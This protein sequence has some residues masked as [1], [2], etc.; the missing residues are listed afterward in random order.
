MEE[1]CLSGGDWSHEPV[2]RARGFVDRWRGLR[3]QGAG[4]SMIL[5]TSSVHAF[6]MRRP[7]WAVGLTERYTVS[8]V[9]MMRPGTIAMFPGCRYVVE[10]PLNVS[11]PP[12]GTSLELSRV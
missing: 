1:V 5:E 8:E 11:P 4:A 6:G 3:N 2:L 10:L 12:I 7:F 9:R